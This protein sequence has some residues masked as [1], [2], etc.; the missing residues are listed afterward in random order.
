V[1]RGRKSQYTPDVVNRITQAIAL[2]STYELA[3]A[4]GGITFETL[5]VW[6]K[7][8]PAFSAAVKDAEGRAVVGWLAKIEKAANDGAWQAAA[9]KLERRY[10]RDYG[11][12]IQEHTGPDGGP[13][14]VA[15]VTARDRVAGKLDEL[16]E[17]RRARARA[18][19]ARADSG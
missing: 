9:W 8:K 5:R 3:A 10:T 6:R 17:R 11:R 4:Y 16:A 12:T 18:G 2:G 7:T 15:D 1:P 14:E 19:E 13:I